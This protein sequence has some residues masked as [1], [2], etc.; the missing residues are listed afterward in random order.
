MLFRSRIFRNA[1]ASA[2]IAVAGAKLRSWWLAPVN[3]WMLWRGRNYLATFAGLQK[4]WKRLSCFVPDL[5]I[6]SRLLG[7]AYVGSGTYDA[8][9][10]ARSQTDSPVSSKYRH[11]LVRELSPSE[12]RP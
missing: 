12:A 5:S 11:G 4:P 1:K 10:L 8:A 9:T 3:V 6:E 2:R 7:T